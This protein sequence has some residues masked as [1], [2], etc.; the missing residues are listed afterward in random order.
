ME[1]ASEMSE[2]GLGDR[3]S[4]LNKGRGKEAVADYRRYADE[5]AKL[6]NDF[7]SFQKSVM[8]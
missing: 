4:G 1:L 8:G 2:E 5:I 3:Y 6:K 7:L